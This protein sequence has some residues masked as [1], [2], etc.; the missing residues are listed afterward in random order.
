VGTPLVTR[1]FAGE[2]LKPGLHIIQE[3]A[4][5]LSFKGG[6]D[7]DLWEKICFKKFVNFNSFSI[8]FSY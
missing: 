1:R 5:D 4:L 8:H 7:H 2:E 6:N 3:L